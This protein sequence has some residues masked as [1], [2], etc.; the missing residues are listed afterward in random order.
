MKITRYLIVLLVFS[1]I[2]YAGEPNEKFT[3]RDYLSMTS[4][5]TPA[6]SPDGKWVVYTATTKE[7]WDCTGNSDLWLTTVDKSKTVQLTTSENQETLPQWSP[8][9]S[10]VAFV[11]DRTGTM[12]VYYIKI[13]GG[14]AKKITDE[15]NGVSKFTWYKDNKHI[16]YIIDDDRDSVVTKA[17]KEAGGGFDVTEQFTTSSLFTKKLSEDNKQKVIGGKYY[18]HEVAASPDGKHFLLSTAPTSDLYLK[19]N[20]GELKLISSKGEEKFAFKKGVKEISHPKF[21]PDG[22][23]LSFIA[24]TVGYSAANGLF[25]M[26]VSGR[27]PK[28][29]TKDFDPTINETAW[30]NNT[31]LLFSTPRNVHTGFYT[32]STNGGEV[33]T[34]IKPYWV[35]SSW[36]YNSK[37]NSIAFTGSRAQIPTELY[38]TKLKSDPA[39]ATLLTD[40][41]INYCK[42]KKL[43]SSQV[44][45]YKSYDGVQ[46]EAV[47]SLP[48]DYKKGNKYPILVLPHGGPD[49]IIMD[50]FSAFGQ[51]FA[52]EGFIVYEPNFR[53]SIG[54][55]SEF[56]KANRGE[57]G[58]ID[59]KDIMWGLNY[60]IAQ[61]MVDTTKMVVGGWSYG[62]YMTNWVIGHTNRFK[63]AV[64]VAGVSN[65]VSNYGQGDINH[66][67]VAKWEFKGVPVLDIENYHHSSPIMYLKSCKTPTLFLH[68]ENDARVHV[69]QA[70]EAYRA[71]DNLGVETELVL[72][73]DAKHGIRAPKQFN[74]VITRWI[75]WYKSHLDMN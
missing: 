63:A 21:S 40:A 5:R 61:G 75:D 18:I 46:I 10:K 31:T 53:G 67:E 54:Y 65:T 28:I 71:L 52:G 23:K 30:L 25:V 11:S 26:D 64:C 74:N 70:W 50:K 36:S 42:N 20:D 33:A 29:L 43:A 47:L 32:V 37:T 6:L 17:E 68:G 44:V 22:K 8:D 73:P 49:G 55:G 48:P 62:G 34:V 72:Y 41:N 27:E 12:Q 39:K 45:Q 15:A 58:Y 38:T 56:Y 51:F 59:Y 7:C 14:E 69:A 57:L 16:A 1:K 19:Y 4:I 3:V 35:S 60:L 66:S 24:C 2:L 9:G 13:D